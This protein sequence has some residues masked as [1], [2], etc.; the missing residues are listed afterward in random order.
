MRQRENT[1]AACPPRLGSCHGAETHAK[2]NQTMPLDS[3]AADIRDSS[4]GGIWLSKGRFVPALEDDLEV[5][6]VLTISFPER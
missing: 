5:S 6:E 2:Q 3:I 1:V 4:P